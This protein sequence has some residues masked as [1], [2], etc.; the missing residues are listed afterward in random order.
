MIKKISIIIIYI[1]VFIMLFSATAF[2]G[3]DPQGIALSWSDDT[4][5]T[6]TVSWRSGI[7]SDQK[8]QVVSEVEYA[9][10]VFENSIQIEAKCKDVSLDNSKQWRYEATVTGLDENT[11]YVYRVGSEYCWSSEKVF[12]TADSQTE[13]ITFMYMGDIQP[14]NDTKAEYAAWEK[15]TETAYQ[16]NPEINFGILGGDIV[17]SGISLEQFDVFRESAESVFSEIPLMAVN[18]NHES[19][20]AGSGKPELYLDVFSLPENGPEGFKEEFYSFDYGADC[21]VTGLNSWVYSGEQG[22]SDAQLDAIDRWVEKDLATSSAKWKVVVLHNPVYAVHSDTTADLI[23]VNWAPLFDKYGVDLVLEGHQH[24][25]S[26]RSPIE[27]G[28]V[29]YGNG[30]TYIMGVSGSKFYDS[31]DETRAEKTVYNTSNYQLIKIDGDTMTVQ[32]MDASGN[33]FDWCSVNQREMTLTRGEYIDMLWRAA[34]SPD[35]GNSP[36]IDDKSKAAAWAYENG[37]ILGY[38]GGVFGPDDNITEEQMDIIGAR[39]EG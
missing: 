27:E 5:T 7:Q 37:L 31:A 32:S 16:L 25:Y 15:L 8:L 2:A 22:L 23:K 29:D 1:L 35:A 3:E 28:K 17:G 18:G 39:M 30:I 9:D 20:F 13:S 12:T 10:S 26:R 38:G 34:G 36:F 6:M 24:V 19:N 4:A 21:H 33:E 11:S 14:V